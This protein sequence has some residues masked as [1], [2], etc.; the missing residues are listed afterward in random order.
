MAKER[1]L[2]KSDRERLEQCATELFTFV[3]SLDPMWAERAKITMQEKGY[4]HLQ[5]FGAWMGQVLDA[6]SHMLS[7]PHKFFEQG[8][9]AAGAERE[10]DACGRTFKVG[11]AGQICCS[12]D[13]WKH[14][15][16]AREQRLI[17]EMDPASLTD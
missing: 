9:N 17:R 2:K 16:Q 10:C 3:C 8:F 7:P 6:G 14:L 12:D 5:L 11:F 4:S 15:P 13:C 1:T